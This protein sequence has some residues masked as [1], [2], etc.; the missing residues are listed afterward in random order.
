[1]LL[2][3]VLNQPLIEAQ[4]VLTLMNKI[5]ELLKILSLAKF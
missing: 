4:K 5:N 3:E 2:N 1:M